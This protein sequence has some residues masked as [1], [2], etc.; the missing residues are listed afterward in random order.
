MSGHVFISYSR[1]DL[2]FVEGLAAELDKFG[3]HTWLDLH[4][5]RGGKAWWPAIQDAIKETEAVLCVLSPDSMQSEYVAKELLHSKAHG[6]PIIALNYRSATI[7]DPLRFLSPDHWIPISDDETE[8]NDGIKHLFLSNLPWTLRAGYAAQHLQT[9]PTDTIP[10]PA[11]LPPASIPPPFKPNPMFVGREEEMRALA[12]A[13]KGGKD[14]VVSPVAAATGLGGIGK[15]QLA[16]EFAHRYGQYFL[17]GVYWFNFEQAETIPAEVARSGGTEGMALQPGWDTLSQEQQVRLVQHAWQ[18]DLPRLLVFDN[19]ESQEVLEH[20]LPTTGGCRVLVT[21]RVQ[22]WPRSL[23]LTLLPLATLPRPESI[24]LLGKFRPDLPTDDP[25][26]DAIAEELGD[27][28]LALHM[29]GSYLETYRHAET[30]QSY[31]EAL[32]KRDLLA[33]LSLTVSDHAPTRHDMHVGRTFALSLQKLDSAD[34]TDQ[35]ALDLLARAAYFAPGHPIPREMLKA[36]VQNLLTEDEQDTLL[37]EK[38][39]LR[40]IQVGLVEQTENGEVVIHRLVCAFVQGAEIAVRGDSLA[41]VENTVNNA[42]FQANDT[43]LPTTM[44]PILPH[45]QHLVKI[46]NHFREDTAGKLIINYGYY[47]ATIGN[48]AQ[49]K[50]YYQ[51]AHNIV[52]EILGP[53]HP[54]TAASLNNLGGILISLGDYQQAKGYFQQALD[55]VQEILGPNHPHTVRSLNNIG[56]VLKSMGNYPQAKEYFQKALT[57]RRE[58]LGPR[59]PDTATCLNNLGGVLQAMGDYPQAQEYLQQT[60][61]IVQEALGPN[62][63][64]TAASLN[65]L[66]SVLQAMGDYPQAKKYYQQAL[67]ITQQILGPKH[68]NT[69]T[70]LNNLGSILRDMG[71]YPQAKEY[72]QQALSIV[73][74]VLGPKHPDTAASLNNLGFILQTMGDNLQ[75]KE[76]FQQVLTIRLEI[77]G[78]KHPDTA[79]CLNNLGGILYILG[80]NL[81]A[82]EYFQ[83]A[84]NIWN[85]T[86]GPKHP[87]TARSLN[88][89]AGVLHAMGNYPQAKEYYQQAFDIWNETL[90]PDHP[91]TQ[92]VRE[93]LE[94]LFQEMEE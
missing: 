27:L 18:S 77:L 41:D 10:V 83:Q 36:S 87:D 84:F 93:N 74:E 72:F 16:A 32:Q 4:N 54:T 17:G 68:P 35:L 57:I 82:K 29:A 85:E 46:G 25:T 26:L 22:N 75:A 24:A 90:G 80:D 92:T 64:H 1:K 52:Q 14:A 2:P 70:S 19:C 42:V 60:L 58:I 11:P 23:G 8:F 44:Q 20:W 38:A 39:L 49:A 7:P 88:N 6:R 34:R 47:L 63:P 53:K 65:N 73:Q 78:P 13:L 43:G 61:D 15:T 28:P 94:A 67:N 59:H 45:L 50:E 5:L 71:D 9:L 69:A 56:G 91:R 40:L 89:L 3:I 37:S 76:Y 31:L 21:S 81:Q 12:A 55:I 66:G 48:Y 86:L 51:Q 30:P 62:H 33:H 79:T